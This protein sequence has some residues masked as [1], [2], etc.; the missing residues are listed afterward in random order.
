MLLKFSDVHWPALP[1]V[2]AMSARAQGWV[3]Q[4][5]P[6]F[7]CAGLGIAGRAGSS[8][9]PQVRLEMVLAAASMSATLVLI[10]AW[11]RNADAIRSGCA[12]AAAAVVWCAFA[13]AAGS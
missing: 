1:G 8:S 2:R 9:L 10:D 4:Q 5:W 12:R 11:M 6:V 3:L 7:A 13:A